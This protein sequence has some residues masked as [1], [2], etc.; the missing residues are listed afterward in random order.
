MPATLFDMPEAHHR[1]TFNL[2]TN[3]FKGNMTPWP[4]IFQHVGVAKG[5]VDRLRTE[6]S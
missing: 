4:D 3:I 6:R 2:R 1:A 5:D